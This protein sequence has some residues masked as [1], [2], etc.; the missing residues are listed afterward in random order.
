MRFDWN[1]DTLKSKMRA[2]CATAIDE[3]MAEAVAD[4]KQGHPEFPPASEPFHRWANRT[5]TATGA[6]RIFDAASPSGPYSVRGSWGADAR[7]SLYLE[8]GTSTSGPTAQER[9]AADDGDP[10]LV[11][12][13]IGPLMARRS[14]IVPS[15]DRTYPSLA[16][17]IAVA[18]N[19]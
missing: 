4:A 1:G 17:K 6:I 8:I 9:A 2:A 16:L 10:N 13:E 12:P 19:S 3:T 7:Q 11:A 15:S 5:G 18:F 14:A